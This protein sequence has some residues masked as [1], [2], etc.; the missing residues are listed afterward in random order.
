[1]GV[2]R[3]IGHHC[4]TASIRANDPGARQTVD[5]DL[6]FGTLKRIL[7]GVAAH[8]HRVWPH[9]GKCPCGKPCGSL[10]TGN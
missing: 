8:R 10:S 5:G 6:K 9:P 7:Q 1:M 2:H 4:T 3:H